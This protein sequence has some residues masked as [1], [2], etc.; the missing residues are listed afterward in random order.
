MKSGCKMRPDREFR[1]PESAAPLR[2]A[3]V[4]ES[5]LPQ[6]ELLAAIPRL[7][8]Y[9]RVLTRDATGADDLVQD[10]LARAWEKRR[11]WRAGTDLRAWLFT[12]MHNVFVNQLARARSDARTVSLEAIA[13]NGAPAQTQADGGPIDRIAL[14]EVARQLDRLPPDQREVL[15]LAAV[16]ELRYDEIAVALGIPI[17]T[18]MS[19]LSRARDKLRRMT[20]RPP[21]ARAVE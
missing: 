20:E 10:T 7:R 6:P 13:E 11:L 2:S 1:N 12:I 21:A 14:L 8:R 9:A 4:T 3:R 19:R 17:G 18:V 5:G 15:I 16:E